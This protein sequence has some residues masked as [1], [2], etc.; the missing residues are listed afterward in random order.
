MKPYRCTV[1]FSDIPTA[2]HF[3]LLNVFI[4]AAF[5]GVT[6]LEVMEGVSSARGSILMRFSDTVTPKGFTKRVLLL[7]ET[8]HHGQL[9]NKRRITNS[10]PEQRLKC[11]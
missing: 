9:M 1:D 10:V 8:D 2:T 6:F 4:F 7:I 5:H 3:T 11:P